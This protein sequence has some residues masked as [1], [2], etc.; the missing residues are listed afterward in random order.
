MRGGG[1]GEFRR[2]GEVLWSKIPGMFFFSLQA[3]WIIVDI[4]TL[5]CYEVIHTEQFFFL[6][7]P[8]AVTVGKQYATPHLPSSIDVCF[9][10]WCT[11]ICLT[12]P[13]P[14]ARPEISGSYDDEAFWQILQ[15]TPLGAHEMEGGDPF[16]SLMLRARVWETAVL[17]SD[18]LELVRVKLKPSLSWHKA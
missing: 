15:C 7:P 5:I 3:T 17:Q 12:K 2:I 14:A 18:M 8:A 9:C 6:P 1:K 11:A 10:E 16:R 13:N 4:L